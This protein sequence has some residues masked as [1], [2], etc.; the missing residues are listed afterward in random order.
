MDL[1]GPWMCVKVASERRA[2]GRSDCRHA[3]LASMA[4]GTLICDQ[5]KAVEAELCGM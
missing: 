3:L 2:V 4:S 1:R 5:P